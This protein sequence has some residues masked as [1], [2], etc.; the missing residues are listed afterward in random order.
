MNTYLTI[1]EVKVD[2]K[3]IKTHEWEVLE[4]ENDVILTRTVRASGNT[5]ASFWGFIEEQPLTVPAYRFKRTLFSK[6]R[7]IEFSDS[8]EN[9]VKDWVDNGTTREWEVAVWEQP[10]KVSMEKLMK[11]DSEKV[12]Q[13]LKERNLTLG[14]DN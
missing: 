13:Y 5:F 14:L 2:G 12:I 1:I 11:F 10:Y 8:I 9:Y 6:K 4:D 7:K 3:V